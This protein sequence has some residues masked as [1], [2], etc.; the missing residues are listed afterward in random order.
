M[1]RQV[2]QNLLRNQGHNIISVVFA[3]DRSF[4]YLP[5]GKKNQAKINNIRRKGKETKTA[6]FSFCCSYFQN[7]PYDKYEGLSES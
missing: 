1:Q 5:K 6:L 7:M 2:S 4:L 3:N